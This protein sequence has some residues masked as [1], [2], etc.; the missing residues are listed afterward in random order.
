MI[1]GSCINYKVCFG[2][3]LG[4]DINSAHPSA[5]CNPMPYKPLTM[6]STADFIFLHPSDMVHTD[7]YYCYFKFPA[8]ELYPSLRVKVDGNILNVLQTCEEHAQWMWGAS[9]IYAATELHAKVYV[10]HTILYEPKVIFR[11][12]IMD[13]YTQRLATTDPAQKEILKA[14]MNTLYGKMS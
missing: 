6:K 9:L 5:M 8:H 3:G 10:Q 7:N 2:I 14:N 4:L 12:Y 11:A 1:G 13:M